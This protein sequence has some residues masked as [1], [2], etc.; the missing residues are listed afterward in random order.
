MSAVEMNDESRDDREG[1]VLIITVGTEFE[2]YVKLNQKSPPEV[3]TS[4]S[5]IEDF[6][7]NATATAEIYTL[8]L[9]D[10]LPILQCEQRRGDGRGSLLA[11]LFIATSTCCGIGYR[12]TSCIRP[13]V[14]I[15]A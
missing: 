5:G 8:A 13:C 3:L 7:F 6:F 14:C 9:H 11:G 2:K 12:S 1:E 10:A 4:L 15:T